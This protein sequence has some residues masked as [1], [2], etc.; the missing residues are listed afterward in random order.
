MLRDAFGEWGL[1]DRMR[2]DNGHPWG[3][4]NDLPR[5][6]ALWL[7]GLGVG[8]I[9]NDPCCP[10]ENAKVERTRG[11]TP[12]W[13][14]PPRCPDRTRLAPRLEWAVHM[15]RE[16]DPAIH[17]QARLEAH[18]ALAQRRR[19]YTRDEEGTLWDLSRV[20]AF[21]SRGVWRRSVSQTG[22]ISLYNRNDRVGRN[23]AGK[24]VSVLFD[25]TSR[26]WVIQDADGEELAR[27]EAEQL[28]YERIMGLDVI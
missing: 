14:E 24:E 16:A 19:P 25:A 28:R 11:V 22:Q 18:P 17:G 9:W 7:I 21:L 2:L 23:H 5:A 3:S 10:E 6:L 15:Q 4:W 26:Q 27:H 12:Q 13:V 8:M 1:P 20:D